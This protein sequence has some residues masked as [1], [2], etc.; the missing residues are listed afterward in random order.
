MS[1][2]YDPFHRINEITNT[3][4]S[5]INEISSFYSDFNK[6][7]NSL[8][9]IVNPYITN[10]INTLSNYAK[11]YSETLTE[12]HHY[13]Q[14]IYNMW[15]NL[16]EELK[17]KN[18]YFPK[19]EL[20]NVLENLTKEAKFYLKKGTILYRAR[21][22][23]NRE[24]PNE[25]HRLFDYI[26]EKNNNQWNNKKI[27]KENEIIKYI[28]DIPCDEWEQDY[29][30]MNNLQ[31]HLFWGYGKKESDA[32]SSIDIS[33]PP[34]RANPSGISYLYTARDIVTA[35]SE[36]QPTIEQFVSIAKIITQKRLNL[37]YFNFPG[38]YK[39]SKLL[40]RHIGAVNE[41]LGLYHFWELEIFFKTLSELF[42]KPILSSTDYYYTTQ[43]ISEFLKNKGFDG[44]Q[45][46]SSLKKRGSNIVLF[47][48]LKDEDDN[49]INYQI[50]DSSLYKIENVRITSTKIL[51]KK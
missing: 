43:Y 44:I 39:N 38:A 37:F 19:N 1:N 9:E 11:A 17:T 26:M 46:K 14:S 30:N 23:S 29:I 15:H 45:Y 25:V 32:P 33:I 36:I 47:N 40:Q 31:N 34:G 18:K 4:K 42:T 49:P 5:P 35:I 21:K 6:A 12:Q 27:I 3:V 2:K 50:L 22:I 8:K 10:A 51:P 28:N 7:V 13:R 41:Q 20:L 16:E 24:F 48:T